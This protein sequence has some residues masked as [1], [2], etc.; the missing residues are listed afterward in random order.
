MG[1]ELIVEDGTND[2]LNDVGTA[3]GTLDGNTVG[4]NVAPTLGLV[5]E[6]AEGND[7]GDTVIIEVGFVLGPEEG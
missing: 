2:G 1:D 5:D 4:Y 3:L 6:L 7:D